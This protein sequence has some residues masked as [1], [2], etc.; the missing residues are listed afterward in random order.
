MTKKEI[1]QLSLL[2]IIAIGIIVMTVSL[3]KGK[4]VVP[5]NEGEIKLLD[6]LVKSIENERV[7]NRLFY[8]HLIQ[9]NN[10]K[11]SLLQV[12]YKERNKIIYEKIPA[13]VVAYNNDELASAA[14][15]FR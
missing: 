1:I 9:E 15:S 3:F 11:D 10:T 12:K 2:G 7:S 4:P 13:T 6:E 8:D 5:N 14:E